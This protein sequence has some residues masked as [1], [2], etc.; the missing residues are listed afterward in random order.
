MFAICLE[1]SVFVTHE[2]VRKVLGFPQVSCHTTSIVQQTTESS[3]MAAS[4]SMS[5]F[6]E[7]L[8][9]PDFSRTKLFKSWFNALTLNQPTH[10]SLTHLLV[11]PHIY[12]CELGQYRLEWW[13]V[14]CSAP[15][16]YLN[17]Y[18][19]ILNGTLRNIILWNSIKNTQIFTHENAFET[20]VCEMAVILTRGKWV[21]K[22]LIKNEMSIPQ[23]TLWM[24]TL[25]T[26]F[27]LLDPRVSKFPEIAL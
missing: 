13:R 21:N 14:A 26:F 4:L 19:L 18:R 6:N 16:L 12:I 20:V 27:S 5:L 1:R 8:H 23:K 2:Q 17:Q 11:V 9:H 25:D 24:Y 7:H 15:S 3:Q 22:M 10:V